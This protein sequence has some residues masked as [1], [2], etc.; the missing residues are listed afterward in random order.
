[1]PLGCHNSF[2]F[3]WVVSVAREGG[4]STWIV[5]GAQKT[6]G[7]PRSR[8][9]WL[10][11]IRLARR[12]QIPAAFRPRRQGLGCGRAKNGRCQFAALYL[13]RPHPRPLRLSDPY[14]RELP[15]V[16]EKLVHVRL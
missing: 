13:A 8:R 5:M 6:A 3:S 16:S 11:Q 15:A 7:L 2:S 14:S 10:E 4:S 1:M 9:P 12:A